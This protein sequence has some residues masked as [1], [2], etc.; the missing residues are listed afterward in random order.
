M[1]RVSLGRKTWKRRSFTRKVNDHWWQP[2]PLCVACCA[3][4]WVCVETDTSST[5]AAQPTTPTA[6]QMLEFSQLNMNMIRDCLLRRW[7][8]NYLEF[9]IY[10]RITYTVITVRVKTLH[11][12]CIGT[13]IG[14]KWEN[15]ICSWVQE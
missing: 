8:H 13:I 1:L 11:R 9:L 6:Q 3:V 14:N 5:P 15:N 2:W 12:L 4:A 7:K 10:N